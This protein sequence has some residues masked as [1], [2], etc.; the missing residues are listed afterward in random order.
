MEKRYQVF[1]SSTDE[2]SQEARREVVQA[3]LSLK[4]MPTGMEPFPARDDDSAEALRRFISERD[5]YVVIVAGRYGSTLPNGKTYTEMAY[6]FATEPKLPVLAFPISRQKYSR[7]RT[8]SRGIL[9][10]QALEH[11][12]ERIKK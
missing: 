11:F 3:L 4:R 5:Y 12:R 1:V 9:A 6:D 8:R 10:K 7:Q 2:D